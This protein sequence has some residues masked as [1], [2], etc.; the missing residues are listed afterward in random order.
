MGEQECMVYSQCDN[1]HNC[2]VCVRQ[3]MFKTGRGMNFE[4]R[5]Q[6]GINR[7]QST[8]KRTPGSG[9]QWHSRGDVTTDSTIISCKSTSAQS[10]R[11]EAK[12]LDEL[13]EIAEAAHK[14]PVLA[15]ELEGHEPWHALRACDFNALIY[16][17]DD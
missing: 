8:A 10:I 12:W 6:R 4:R 15:I 7:S 1:H 13:V 9:N 11:I 17:K 2:L 14:I 3:H 5:T 16:G